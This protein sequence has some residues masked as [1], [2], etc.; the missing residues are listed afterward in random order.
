[1]NKSAS[2]KEVIETITTEAQ[3]KKSQEVRVV[4]SM[5]IGKVVRQGD[6]YLHRVSDDHLHGAPAPRQLVQGFTQGS[7]HVAEAPAQVFEGKQA[8]EWAPR[9]LVGPVIVTRNRLRVTH[10]EHAWVD[11]PVGTYQVTFQRDA[12]TNE[13]VRD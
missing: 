6:I 5:A 7:R 12:R 11:L 8:P 2:V 4:E 10:P 13:A 1:M 3:V 9:A